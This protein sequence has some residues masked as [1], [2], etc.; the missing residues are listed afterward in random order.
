M[1]AKTGIMEKRQIKLKSKKDNNQEREEA[2]LHNEFK[3][4]MDNSLVVIAFFRRQK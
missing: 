3:D 4:K 1:R 2:A